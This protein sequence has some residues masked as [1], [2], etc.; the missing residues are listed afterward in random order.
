MKCQARPLLI[1]A[2]EDGKFDA[3]IDPKLHEDYDSEEVTRM[4]ACA[5][6]CVRHSARH[7]PRM[8]QVVRALEGNLSLSELNEGIVPGHSSAYSHHGSSDYDSSQYQED[9]KKFR[10]IALESQEQATSEFSGPTSEYGL[11]PSSS[12]SG[13]QQ[14]SQEMELGR[15]AEDDRHASKGS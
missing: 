7:R 5:A 12:S 2:L 15:M 1:R 6:A 11:Q 4:V 9:L 8:T 3:I 13:V 14:T 10:M